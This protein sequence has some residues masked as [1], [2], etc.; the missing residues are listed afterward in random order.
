[1]DVLKVHENG[2]DDLVCITPPDCELSSASSIQQRDRGKAPGI[3]KSNGKW[4]GYSWCS[5][6][7]SRSEIKQWRGWNA[8]F[9]LR[10]AFFPGID[11]DVL[12]KDLA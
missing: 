1:M 11:I 2:F 9:G 10:S 3:R 8:N 4:T 5:G 7:P 6:K 12:D